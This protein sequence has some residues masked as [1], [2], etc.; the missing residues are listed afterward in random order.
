MEV[1]PDGLRRDHLDGK[2]RGNLHTLG[3]IQPWMQPF[4]VTIP[5]LESSMAGKDFLAS[6][7]RQSVNV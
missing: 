1:V 7:R 2:P 3:K 6:G 4:D 5:T